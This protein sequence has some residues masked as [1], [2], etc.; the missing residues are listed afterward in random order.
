MR[1]WLA[2]VGEPLPTDEGTSRLLRAGIIANQLA[3]RGHQVLWW[4]SSFDHFRKRQR[5]KC[6]TSILLKNGVELR[7]LYGRGYQRNV[8]LSRFLD[9]TQVARSFLSQAPD[10]PLPDIILCSYPTIELALACTRFG[11]EYGIPVILDIRDLWPDIFLDLTPKWASPI[12]RLLLEP[13][14]RQAREACSNASA[15][16]AT[17]PRF[18]EWGVE[19]AGRS[20]S[21]FDRD[22]P[23]GYVD[24]EP[25]PAQ[26]A[27]AK[28]YWNDLGVKDDS[29]VFTACFF[30]TMG[31]QFDLETVIDAARLLELQGAPQIR[32]VLCGAGDRLDNLRRRAAGLESVLLPGWVDAP[33]IWMLM[34]MSQVGLAPYLNNAGFSDNFPNKTIEYMSAGLPVVSSLHG[35]YKKFLQEQRIGVSYAYREPD[36]LADLLVKLVSDPGGINAMSGR[37]KAI[38]SECFEADTVYGHMIDY[39]VE[40]ATD[41]CDTQRT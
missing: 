21:E 20:L 18:V 23:L 36:E 8:S 15:I 30:G 37:A 29:G 6:D 33:K 9:H 7:I 5:V 31:R 32:F 28:S 13:M 1:V 3:R 38:F 39:L 16:C 26:L 11:R 41:S 35:Y 22:F 12:I 10:V 19:H 4:T 24:V 40:M 17:S 27:E 2:T 14:W 34:R 25:L